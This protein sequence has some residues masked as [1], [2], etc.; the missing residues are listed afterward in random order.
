M[1]R[2]HFEIVDGYT[3]EDPVGLECKTE[4]EAI[5]VAQTIARQIERDV[6]SSGARKISVKTDG[7]LEVQKVPIK[8]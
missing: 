7:G 5:E 6:K 1:P 3:I 2:F 4:A 8:R